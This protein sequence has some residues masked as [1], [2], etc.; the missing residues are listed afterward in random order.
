M[1]LQSHRGDEM[2]KRTKTEWAEDI[3]GTLCLF[4]LAYGLWLVACAL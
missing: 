2:T 4:G 1:I 3:A